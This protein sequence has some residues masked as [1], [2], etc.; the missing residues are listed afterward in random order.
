MAG[1]HGSA[2]RALTRAGASRVAPG[3]GTRARRDGQPTRFV[4]DFAIVHLGWP[5]P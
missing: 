2:D 3:L 1:Y 4:I 5:A